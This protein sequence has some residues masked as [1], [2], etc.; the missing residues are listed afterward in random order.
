M[1]RNFQKANEYQDHIFSIVIAL[2]YFHA[3]YIFH[4]SLSR[5]YFF[6]PVPLRPS[7]HSILHF[8]HNRY[9]FQRP[10]RR[11][12]QKENPACNHCQLGRFYLINRDSDYFLGMITLD[13]L[14]C[15]HAE[16]SSRSSSRLST[17]YYPARQLS[18]ASL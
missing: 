5:R 18:P 4:F 10:D 12:G 3:G 7:P 1:P 15:A 17:S 13:E 14:H 9:F 2:E 6:V 16:N 11:N 8:F